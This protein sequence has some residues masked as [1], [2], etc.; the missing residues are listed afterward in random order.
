MESIELFSMYSPNI[1][2]F[3]QLY[4]KENGQLIFDGYDHGTGV[5]EWWG[6]SD[7]EYTYA[8]EPEDV[9]KLYALL[10]VRKTDRSSL[11]LELKKRFGNNEGYSKFGR[12]MTEN[13]IEYR[14]FNWI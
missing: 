6:D 11:L 12:F 7:Y 14:P 13:N 3:M 10:N 4:F 8:I 5:E 2:V 9:E 1:K